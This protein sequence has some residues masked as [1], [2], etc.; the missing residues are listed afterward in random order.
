MDKQE[1][2]SV[3]II[4][5]VLIPM[6]DGVRLAGNLHK[7][8]GDGPFPCIV[9][10]VPYHKDGRAGRGY[11][12][13]VHRHF[14]Q[15]VQISFRRVTSGV[16]KI[17]DPVLTRLGNPLDVFQNK[18]AGLG[19]LD[20]EGNVRNGARIGL[21]EDNPRPHGPGSF[22]ESLRPGRDARRAA[23]HP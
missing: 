12:D 8:A 3:E 2:P 21:A 5:N 4:R 22:C 7:P 18:A 6:R 20:P 17:I 13:Q 11:A 19:G 9:N 23:D 1:E 16:A 10:Y 15:R 14:A